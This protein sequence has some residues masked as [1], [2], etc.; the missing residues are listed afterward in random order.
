MDATYCVNGGERMTG[1]QIDAQ[2]IPVVLEGNFRSV[3]VSL[4]ESV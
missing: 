2:G 1:K 4:K 3:S